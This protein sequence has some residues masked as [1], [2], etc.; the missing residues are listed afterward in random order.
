MTLAEG[1]EPRLSWALLLG[2][3]SL[4]GWCFEWGLISFMKKEAV[5]GSKTGALSFSKE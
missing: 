4:M 3:W 5:F 2:S 1:V